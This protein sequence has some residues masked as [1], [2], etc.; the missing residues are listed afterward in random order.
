MWGEKSS[1]PVLQ[2]PFAF[3]GLEEAA[4]IRQK[5]GTVPVDD[6]RFLTVCRNEVGTDTKTRD[7]P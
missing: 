4:I 2:V 5:V 7:S 6:T 1:E 3:A